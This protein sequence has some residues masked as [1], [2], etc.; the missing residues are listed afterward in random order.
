MCMISRIKTNAPV[1][2]LTRV[3]ALR[4]Q[5]VPSVLAAL[6]KYSRFIVFYLIFLYLHHSS[7]TSSTS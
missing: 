1:M 2:N 3:G 7:P 5:K 4:G 6:M